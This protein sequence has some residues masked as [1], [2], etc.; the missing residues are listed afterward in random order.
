MLSLKSSSVNSQIEEGQ[1]ILISKTCKHLG[2]L[3]SPL[4]VFLD[5]MNCSVLILYFT[6]V[7]R[8][9][10]LLLLL[11]ILVCNFI[12]KMKV[13]FV[14]SFAA[15][16]CAADIYYKADRLEFGFNHFLC[17]DCWPYGI[18]WSNEFHSSLKAIFTS[19]YIWYLHPPSGEEV[20]CS[21]QNGVT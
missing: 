8:F 4:F 15:R 2:Y 14:T 1:T 6:F 7:N 11:S 17:I 10:L 5:G 20:H 9:L 16:Y 19:I 13:L 3:W 21:K 12:S 18:Q